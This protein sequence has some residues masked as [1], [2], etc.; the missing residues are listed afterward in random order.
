MKKTSGS[1]PLNMYVALRL[2]YS[3]RE[4]ILDFHNLF[5][6]SLKAAGHALLC[7][8]KSVSRLTD[9]G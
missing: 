2:S 7:S 5:E 1:F 8:L 4:S 3:V 6:G 9:W